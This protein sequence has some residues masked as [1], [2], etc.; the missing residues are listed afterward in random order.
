MQH[1][2]SQIFVSIASITIALTSIYSLYSLEI[3]AYP[4]EYNQD[5][6]S[7]RMYI[8]QLSVCG[9]VSGFVWFAL[10]LFLPEMKAG[11]GLVMIASAFATSY[12]LRMP[13]SA[14]GSIS[15]FATISYLVFLGTY[16]LSSFLSPNKDI[17]SSMQFS[18]FPPR[19]PMMVNNNIRNQ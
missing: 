8:R 7:R 5:E 13:P 16:T 3:L 18:P 12:I 10:N 15:I 1:I 17:L 2:P 14:R 11:T 6:D 9:L 4:E 19:E